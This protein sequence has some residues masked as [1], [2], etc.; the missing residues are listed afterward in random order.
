MKIALGKANF[1]IICQNSY[2]YTD[3]TKFLYQLSL[4][5]STFFLSWLLHFGKSLLVSALKAILEGRR[6]FFKGALD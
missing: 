6:E 4:I 1:P 2:F 5:K 3:K